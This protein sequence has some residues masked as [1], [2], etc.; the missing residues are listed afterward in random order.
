M[1]SFLEKAN[2][3]ERNVID[4]YVKKHVMLNLSL[5]FTGFLT[6][7]LF[8]FGPFILST[9]LPT[10]AKYPFSID[11]NLTR[12]IIYL[13]QSFVAFQVASGMTVDCLCAS[14]LWYTAARFK[15][16]ADDFQNVQDRSDVFLRIR[17]HQHLL[18]YAKNLR[19]AIR[20]IVFSTLFTATISI[21]F[22]SVPFFTTTKVGTAAFHSS[23]IGLPPDLLKCWILILKMSQKG[24]TINIAGILPTLSLAY[25]FQFISKVFSY[26]ATL[27][28]V[29]VKEIN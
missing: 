28:I 15:I 2:E 11:S 16:L 9:P 20:G 13:H 14:L 23:W 19:M 1:T 7:L 22:A 17:Q 29:I 26:L 27:R 8:V 21:V 3:K 10:D 4:Y 5:S 24:V 6:A 25:F 12:F 18:I